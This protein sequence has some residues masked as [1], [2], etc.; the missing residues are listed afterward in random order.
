MNKIS[1]IIVSWNAKEYLRNCLASL[2]KNGS[3]LI[4]EVIVVDNASNDGSPDMVA[5]EFPDVTVIRSSHNLGFAGGNNLGIM[6]AS[7][8]YLALVNSDVIIHPGCFERLLAFLENHRE[9]ALAGPK[10]LDREDRLQTTCR[11]FPTLL[12]TVGRALALDRA[13]TRCPLLSREMPPLPDCIESDVEVLTGC[14]WV[15]RHKAVDE[16]G[17][18][19][20]RFFF[21]AEDVDWC[22]RFRDTGWKVTYVPQACATHFGGGSSENAPL[23]YSIEM[24]RSNLAFWRK[25]N[26]RLGEVAYYLLSIFHYSLRLI[27]RGVSVMIRRDPTQDA[28]FKFAKSQVCLRWLITG[29]EV[30]DRSPI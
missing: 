18:L 22:K 14:F 19:D 8:D 27:L 2:Y 25:H 12:N 20:E 5:H 1:V 15:A 24:L 16:V 10:I 29:K 21:Y 9:V 6:Q 13:L 4:G 28:M 23:R 7:H 3:S 17:N 30:F 26:G 11:R